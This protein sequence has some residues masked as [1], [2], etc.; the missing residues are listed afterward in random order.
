MQILTQYE[1]EKIAFSLKIKR[2]I[3][4]IAKALG[5]NPGVISR[6]ITRNRL[7][8]GTYDP[9]RA[10]KKADLRS[11]KTNKRKLESDWRLH[12][13]VEK[14]LKTGWSPELIAGRL[15]EHPPA[16]LYGARVS[17]EQIYQY[18]YEGEGKWEGWFHYLI[19]KN[20]ARRTTRSRKKQ[21]K[22]LI[23]ERLSII[24]RPAIIDERLRYGDWES[25]Q[26]EFKKQR[27]RLSVQYER[28]AM[29]TRIHKVQNKTARENEQ[30]IGKTLESFPAAFAKSI[31]FDNGKENVC[32]TKIRDVFNMDTF[33]CDPYKS[34]QKGG[35]ENA[36]G[37]IRRYLPK[38]TN[39]ATISDED[40]L[41]I[42]EKLNNRPR[43]KLNYL[44][45]N[46]ALSVALNS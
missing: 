36:I 28:K 38:T 18:I 23:K 6:E 14:K 20:H 27:E 5:R 3:R 35:V 43:K 44:T 26:A 19:R 46:E 39:L 37:L 24:Q 29:I 40:I 34:W 4:D 33:F 25:D 41:V 31:T 32:H 13:W 15:K 22:T 30:A 7:S 21:A 1:R 8:D 16:S 11:H 42:Q 10:Q 12:D 2:K 17:H 9:V 45:P